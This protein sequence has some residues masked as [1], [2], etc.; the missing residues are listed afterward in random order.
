[1]SSG[2]RDH[3]IPGIECDMVNSLESRELQMAV[4]HG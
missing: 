1:M 4:L 2:A 3:A